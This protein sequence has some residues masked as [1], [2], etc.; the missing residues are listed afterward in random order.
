MSSVYTYI[1]ITKKYNNDYLFIHTFI[2]NPCSSQRSALSDSGEESTII[3]Q[4]CKIFNLLAS[5]D[6][7]YFFLS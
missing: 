4:V 5:F 6:S 2:L 3:F 7:D 1:F